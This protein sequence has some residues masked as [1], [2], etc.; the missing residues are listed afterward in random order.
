MIEVEIGRT[1]TGIRRFPIGFRIEFLRCWDAAI[2]RG[3]KARL[4]REYN[5][6]RSTIDPWLEA[7]DRGKYT[8]SMVAT[9]ERSKHRVD[10]R[11][12]AELA[13]LRKE[14]AKLRKQVAKSEAAQEILGKAFELLSG[15]N[16]SSNEEQEQDPIP[17]AL[18][19]AEAYARW[20]ERNN[21]S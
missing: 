19:S 21:L 14:N 13:R 4:L 12:R 7:R 6:V 11:E 10:A 9:A 16:Q 15:I 17:P 3:D 5:L 20:L 18:M 2:E 1:A 8:A